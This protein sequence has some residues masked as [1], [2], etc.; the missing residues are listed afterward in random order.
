MKE[1]VKKAIQVQRSENT[2]EL[3][4]RGLNFS[5][6][7]FD[8]CM[9]RSQNF[10]WNKKFGAGSSI[11][12]Q[13][14]DNLIILDACRYDTFKNT[15]Q[16]DNGEIHKRI[17][18]GSKTPEFLEKTFKDEV[19][20][21]TVY[22]TANP[23]V[24]K[25]IHDKESIFHSVESLLNEWD[26]ETQTVLPE[27][28]TDRALTIANKYPSKRLIVHYL[29]PHAPFIGKT[30]SRIRSQTGKTIGGLNPDRKYTDEDTK[31][32]NTVSYRDILR[33][34]D[35]S[36][37]MVR[38]A[39]Q[40]SLEIVSN[41]ALELAEDLQGKS[42]ITSDHGELL[43]ERYFPSYRQQWEHPRGI[44]TDELCIVPWAE[45]EYDERKNI[46]SEPPKRRDSIN[47]GIV[48]QRLESLGYK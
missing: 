48:D 20:H 33:E 2:L 23:Q 38:D 29:Q 36:K 30:A 26:S 8:R 3:L 14:W 24:L 35:V 41:N 16:I 45:L 43:G 32:I 17:T 31:N 47:Q 5:F 27:D 42:V 25:F 6:D 34:E 37:E 22:V 19:L 12:D 10:Y 13:K 39:Y 11:L 28:V 46:C 40:E 44:R 7:E 1:L 4:R 9:M 15:I 18:L 21:D